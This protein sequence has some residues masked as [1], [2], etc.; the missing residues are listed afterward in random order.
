VSKL[1]SKSVG[2]RWCS[3]CSNQVGL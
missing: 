1:L 2:S 3:W